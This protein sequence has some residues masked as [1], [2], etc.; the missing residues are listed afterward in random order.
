MHR[1]FSPAR[2]LWVSSRIGPAVI[3][4]NRPFLVKRSG[5]RTGRRLAMKA[6]ECSGC[7]M[8]TSSQPVVLLTGFEPFGGE[9]TNPSAYAVRA[10]HGRVLAGC[11]VEA[12]VLP[13][14]FGVALVQ[15]RQALRELRPVLVIA[16]GQ[17]GGRSEVSLE[18]VAINVDDARIPDNRGAQPVDLPVEAGGPAAYWSTLPIKAI[19]AALR[20]RDI[21]AGVSQTA[22]TFVCNHVFYGLMHSL[23][24]TD[25]APRGGFIH[26]PYSS[27][28]A[29]RHGGAPGLGLETMID[30]LGIAVTTALRTVDDLAVAGGAES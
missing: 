11:R 8:Q 20:E 17:A 10:L 15:L 5:E 24:E 28:Q 23:A 2:M 9:A 30:A 4:K 26:L 18:R 16:T 3:G 6:G 29:A 21:P 25:A 22:G 7:G 27:E 13:V 1:G 12:R 19:V 14:V